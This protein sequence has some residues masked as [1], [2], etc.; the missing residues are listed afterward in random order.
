MLTK[1]LV[2]ML[3]IASTK[4]PDFVLKKLEKALEIEDNKLSKILL[5]AL[6]KNA[7]IAEEEGIPICQDTGIPVFFVESKT[8]DIYYDILEAVDIATE[9]GYLR[10]NSVSIKEERVVGNFPEVYF[11]PIR[12]K[13]IKISLLLKGGGT[14]YV[15]K[16]YSLPP[17]L[18]KK[19]LIDKIK[20]A[21][22]EAGSKPCPPVFIGVGIGGTEAKALL[23]AELALLKI[24][25]RNPLTSYL[26]ELNKVN[27]G[28][29]GIG[30]RITVLDINVVGK[31]RHPA[32]F[33]VGIS[34]N[35]WALRRAF[36]IY[37]E[38]GVKIWN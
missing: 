33:L 37:S 36:L 9:E 20:E 2:E 4:I 17:M 21:L 26:H 6:I 29:M 24:P 14:S 38:E 32:T 13:R 23:N 25:E 28:P 15:S 22:I 30:G 5:K 7:K 31:Y 8:T 34:F 27:I 10:P 19:L 35:C 16:L 3:K 11:F 18:G 12:E 1:Y